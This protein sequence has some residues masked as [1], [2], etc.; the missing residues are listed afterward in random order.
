MKKV[1]KGV[2][3]KKR[4]QA[5]T[6]SRRTEKDP[7]VFYR[8]VFILASLLIVLAIIAIPNQSTLRQAVQ[9]VSTQYG[10]YDK[11]VIPLPS[12]P[13]AVSY[14]IYYGLSSMS[15]NFNNAAREIPSIYSTYTI[16]YL[17]LNTT[18]SYRI[19]AKD[20]SGR[21]IYWTPVKTLTNE[22]PM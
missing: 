12:V 11:A 19:S 17:R 16:N 22:Q 21:E 13:N 10:Q 7:V 14:N 1:K 4:V 2:T 8:R 15:P 3:A 18:Y 5:K 6:L 20:S 9:G